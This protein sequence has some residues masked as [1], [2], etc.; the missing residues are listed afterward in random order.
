[1]IP[2]LKPSVTACVQSLAPSLL[3]MLLQVRLSSALVARTGSRLH[4][5]SGGRQRVVGLRVSDALGFCGLK[6][7]RNLQRWARPS[8]IPCD[9]LRL[10]RARSAQRVS[11]QAAMFGLLQ[12]FSCCAD[13]GSWGHQEFCESCKARE[14]RRA[15]DPL[16]HA[17]DS[18][19]EAQPFELSDAAHRT[20]C[21]DES[22]ASCG[23]SSAR[24]TVGGA[25]FSRSLASSARISYAP[26]GSC[27]RHTISRICRRK[28]V[29]L[30]SFA[31]QT[32]SAVATARRTHRA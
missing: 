6:G 2:R 20:E 1:M 30:T 3:R 19:F 27:W 8:G 17:L 29:R 18:T 32:R 12:E 9:H 13:I 5:G 15:L 22:P 23:N 24:Y 16:E 4:S 21:E 14:L 11:D 31:A 10:E 7:R 28:G 26:I 25:A